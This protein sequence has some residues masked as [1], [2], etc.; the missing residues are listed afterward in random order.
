MFE[1]QPRIE[2][3]DE[4]LTNETDWS[5]LET[6]GNDEPAKTWA[7][8][9]AEVPSFDQAKAEKLATEA[10]PKITKETTESDASQEILDFNDFKAEVGRRTLEAVQLDRGDLT[11]QVYLQGGDFMS[12]AE[13]RRIKG[14]A[15]AY[16]PE[17]QIWHQEVI[18]KTLADARELSERLGPPPRIIAM[19]GGCGSGKTTAVRQ[20]YGE[21]GI[22]DAN[23]DVPGAV[24]PDY[25]KTVIIEKA[26]TDLGL[27]ISSEQTHL[28]STGVCRMYSDKLVQEQGVSM[29]VD[30][31]LD[32]AGDV[33]ELIRAGHETGKSVEVLDNDIPI[34]LSAFRVL[35]REIGGTDP[36]MPY[37][38]VVR[39]YLGI[40]A[41]RA[42]V[43]EACR[44]EIV[45]DYALRAFDPE[46]K[47]QIEVI[48][49]VDGELVYVPGKEDLARGILAQGRS[50]AMLEAESVGEQE[51]TES[52]IE[53]FVKR[54]GN[55]DDASWAKKVKDTLSPYLGLE[56]TLKEALD[57]KS[58][59]VMLS[60]DLRRWKEKQAEIA[61][62]AE[63]TEAERTRVEAGQ[64][65][66]VQAQPE[67]N[68]AELAA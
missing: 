35:R 42:Q 60:E 63:Q 22:F 59:G 6:Y 36:N 8:F 43:V 47:E 17:R 5:I 23:G 38:A 40:R 68:P 37:Q 31:Q 11:A 62:Q 50:E 20:R 1:G 65:E 32:G 67:T 13:I 3:G 48:K 30:K 7:D 45:S 52:Y 14:K 4:P 19:R 56:M 24:K 33:E 16:T 15:E 27:A 64:L 55:P 25:F 12:K 34:E 18:E 21:S 28:E 49:K 61:R 26:R 51:I 54:Y 53:D 10:A 41:N 29:L 2:T 58:D 44:D 39:G 57:S 46:T 66:S 9:A